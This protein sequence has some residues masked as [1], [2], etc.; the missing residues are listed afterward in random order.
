MMRTSLYIWLFYIILLYIEHLRLPHVPHEPTSIKNTYL[1]VCFTVLRHARRKCTLTF[2][3]NIDSIL[4][5]SQNKKEGS[6]WV[7]RIPQ[8]KDSTG[9]ASPVDSL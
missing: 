7:Y 1:L 3:F 2:P 9:Y 5:L 4:K 6:G 8:K